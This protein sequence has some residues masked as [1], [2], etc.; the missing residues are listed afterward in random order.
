MKI[1]F[2]TGKGHRWAIGR[3]LSDADR[4]GRCSKRPLGGT[5]ART[6]EAKGDGTVDLKQRLMDDLRQATR[7]RDTE[8][9]SAI[10][11]LRAAI[12]NLEIAR[13]D[14]K[15]PKYGQPVTEADLLMVV[16]REA[17]QRREALEFARKAGR[18]DLVAKEERMLAVIESYLPRQ[19]TRDEIAAEVLPLIA[20]LGRDFRKV[21]PVAA[22]R[23]RGRADGRLVAEVVRELIE[24]GTPSSG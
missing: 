14:P 9:V 11:M 8:R 10:R 6:L 1:G 7:E 23:L 24:R 19:L 5:I 21:M 3:A 2:E 13:T 18:D 15:D 12:Q 4:A 17:N 16:Q 20:E 22:E